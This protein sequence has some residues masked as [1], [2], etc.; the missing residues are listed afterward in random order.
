MA[1]RFPQCTARAEFDWLCLLGEMFI[2]RTV[3]MHLSCG[4]CLREHAR[5]QRVLTVSS[6]S[7]RQ[8]PDMSALKKALSELR[9]T[10]NAR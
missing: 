9:G 4:T 10:F 7:G 1:M 2:A 3:T 8:H 5:L 6:G